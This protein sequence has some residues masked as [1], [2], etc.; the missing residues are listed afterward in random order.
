MQSAIARN[1]AEALLALAAKEN[2]RDVYGAYMAALADTLER[3]ETFKRFLEAPTVSGARKNEVLGKALTGQAPAMFVR[4]I[5]KL[6]TNGRQMLLGD[7]FNEYN[8]LLDAEVGRVHARVTI[9]RAMSDAD[10]DALAASL[11]AA[12]GKTVVPHLTVNPA[13]LGGLV[14]RIGDTVM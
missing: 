8:T 9:S 14:V 2:A 11:T 7:V 13:I 1:Y 10:R 5:Q 12:M 4:F 3:D 6:V